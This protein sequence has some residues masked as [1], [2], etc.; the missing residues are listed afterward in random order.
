MKRLIPSL[1]DAPDLGDVM[2]AFPANAPALLTLIDGIMVDDAPVHQGDRE[3]IAAF[4]SALNACQYC[5]DSHISA[6]SAFGVEPGVL[7]DLVRDVDSAPIEAPLKPLL[8][9]IAKLTET[10]ARLTESDAAEVF[11]A[12]W[13]EAALYSAIEVCA[14][15]SFVNRIVL[16]TGVVANPAGPSDLSEAEK[17]ERRERRYTDWGIAMGLMGASDDG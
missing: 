12:G 4:V 10:P 3:L 5:A 1:P 8:K 14:L 17:K 9:Y 11:A 16:G 7:A 13:S 2:R 15:F 6:A